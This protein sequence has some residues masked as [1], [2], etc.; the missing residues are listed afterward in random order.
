M[1]DITDQETVKNILCAYLT[2]WASYRQ[3]NIKDL[4][5]GC[6]EDLQVGY[7]ILY[8]GLYPGVTVSAPRN[9][10]NTMSFHIGTTSVWKCSMGWQVAD[11]I[12]GHYTNH[13]L[14]RNCSLE[15]WDRPLAETID[16]VLR[17]R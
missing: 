4:L 6:R 3:K 11:W 12:D 13:L 10:D 14:E 17:E 9:L 15:K 16:T 5:K 1:S 8:E 7:G 2:R